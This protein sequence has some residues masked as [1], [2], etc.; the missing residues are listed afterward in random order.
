[1]FENFIK[2]PFINLFCGLILFLTSG[3]ETWISIDEFIVGAH[4]GI[5][6]FSIIQILKA[7]PDILQSF[8]EINMAVPST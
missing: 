8:K 2:S 3:Y 7:I 4:H 1:M 6:I 5:L